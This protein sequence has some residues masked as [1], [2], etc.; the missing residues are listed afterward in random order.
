MVK[1]RLLTR[2]LATMTFFALVGGSLFAQ[3]NF[4][5]LAV[6]GTVTGAKSAQLKVGQMVD[7]KDKITVKSAGYV[8]LAHKNGKAVEIRKA[9][10]Y[11]VKELDDKAKKQTG[12]ATSKFA[13]YVVSELTEVQEPIEFTDAR[14]AHMRTTGSVD[15]AY[16]EGNFWDSVLTVVGAPGEMQALAA[17]DADAVAS[18][19]RLSVIMPRHSRLL[20]DSIAFLWHRSPKASGYKVVIVDRTNQPV[21]S[22]TLTDTLYIASLTDLGMKQGQL[23]YWHVEGSTDPGYRTDEYALYP[24]AGGERSSAENLI[25]EVNSELDADDAAIGKLVLAAAMEEMGLFYEAHRSYKDAVDLAPDIQNYKRLYA[26]FLHRQGLDQEAY[27][28]YR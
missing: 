5:V 1:W 9:G 14:R 17:K 22:H 18:G 27:A 21:H 12:S 20:A 10:T 13:K 2:S 25:G 4:K 19:A 3:S 16:G 11:N 6:R 8:S 23:Y 26:E 28:A 24:L 15:R 7:N